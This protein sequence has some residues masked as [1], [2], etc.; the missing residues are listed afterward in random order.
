VIKN[1]QR[2]MKYKM[3]KVALRKGKSD[4]RLGLEEIRSLKK[5]LMRNEIKVQ[6]PRTGLHLPSK[7]SNL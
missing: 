4:S 2:K 1:E 5:G 6:Y 3:R 7:A